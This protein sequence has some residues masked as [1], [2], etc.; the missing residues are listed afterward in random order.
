[1]C[2]HLEC[3]QN[4]AIC[5]NVVHKPERFGWNNKLIYLQGQLVCITSKKIEVLISKATYQRKMTLRCTKTAC[6]NKYTHSALYSARSRSL[7]AHA[8]S[9]DIASAHQCTH[10]SAMEYLLVPDSLSL[11]RKLASLQ[12]CSWASACCRLTLPWYQLGGGEEVGRRGKW[13]ER[14]QIRDI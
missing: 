4:D 13:W 8:H 6:K 1:M 10:L 9:K 5:V 3:M 11:T 7:Q 2:T 14:Q 12:R